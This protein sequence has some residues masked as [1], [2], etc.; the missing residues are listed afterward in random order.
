MA[1]FTENFVLSKEHAVNA[2]HQ[3]ASLTIEIRVDLLFKRRLV[4]VPRS[5]TY[6]KSNGLFFGSTGYILIHGNR[7][8]DATTFSKEGSNSPTGAFRRDKDDID[9]RG[10]VDFGEIFEDG[11]EAVG[12]VECLAMS[13]GITSGAFCPYFSFGKLGL[14]SRPSLALSGI[15]E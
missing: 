9:I 7:G 4:E 6:P 5:H 2:A 15:T 13:V 11:G 12:E 14:D 10:N 8:V 1:S 3:A